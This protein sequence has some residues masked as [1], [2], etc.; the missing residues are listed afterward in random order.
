M[1]RK[2]RVVGV[3]VPLEV[4]DLFIKNAKAQHMTKSEY[5]RF[6]L[7]QKAT[8]DLNIDI[9]NLMRQYWLFR[10]NRKQP[11]R[12]VGLGLCV[13]QGKVLIVSRTGKDKLVPGL[14]W[15]FPGGTLSSMEFRSELETILRSKLGIKVLVENLISARLIPES[16]NSQEAIVALYFAMQSI[17][18]VKII[19]AV[20]QSYR[21]V[22]PQEI[23]KY[24]STSTSDEV[25]RYL[26]DR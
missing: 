19:S 13:K 5:F 20:Y 25:T 9:A 24:F 21:W 2:T 26:L 22:K 1:S 7:S 4:E 16:S 17:K 23:F 3:S 12:L 14:K 11:I 15:A 6:L 8:Q 18:S 10:E